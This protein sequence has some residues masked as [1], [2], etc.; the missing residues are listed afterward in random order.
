MPYRKPHPSIFEA[1]IARLGMDACDMLFVGD[2]IDRDVAGAQGV[3]MTAAWINRDGKKPGNG[4]VP[5]F[6]IHH[7]SELLQILPLTA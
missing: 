5:D 7:L 6:D 4:I 3:G 2:D 1:S